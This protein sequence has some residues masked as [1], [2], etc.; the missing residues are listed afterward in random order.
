[1]DNQNKEIQY[2]KSPRLGDYE[3]IYFKRDGVPLLELRVSGTALVNAPC[4]LQEVNIYN[5][6]YE[7]G[8]Q[9]IEKVKSF[10]IVTLLAADIIDQKLITDWDS[11]R[12]EPTE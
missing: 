5:W 7:T 12:R 10:E 3:G 9:H 1:M 8:L 4:N 6:L 2:E 11:L